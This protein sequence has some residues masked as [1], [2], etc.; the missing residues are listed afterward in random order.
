MV[1]SPALA[2]HAACQWANKELTL[3]HS[4]AHRTGR[5]VLPLPLTSRSSVITILHALSTL[6]GAKA[7]KLHHWASPSF[8]SFSLARENIACQPLTSVLPA[9]LLAT[10]AVYT[11]HRRVVATLQ[12]PSASH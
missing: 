1:L 4:L 10:L 6:R 7:N 3:I 11:E 2:K 5:Y 9:R 8:L 12:N